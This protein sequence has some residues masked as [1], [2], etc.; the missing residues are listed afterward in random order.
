MADPFERAAGMLSQKPKSSAGAGASGKESELEASRARQAKIQ[1]RID[2]AMKSGDKATAN[3]HQDALRR[4]QQ[5]RMTLHKQ[6]KAAMPSYE[7][8]GI[9][10]ETGPALVHEGEMVIP[11]E[12]TSRAE[13]MMGGGP[14]KP[15]S[16]MASVAEMPKVDR[17]SIERTD[18]GGFIVE[19]EMEGGKKGGRPKRIVVMDPAQL[20]SHLDEVFGVETEAPE[21]SLE[22]PVEGLAEEG[23][24]GEEI[25]DEAEV[26][27]AGGEMEAAAGLEDEA[28]AANLQQVPEEI[29]GA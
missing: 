8:G 4:E 18:N 7:K 16:M 6:Q 20:H 14:P 12:Q 19:H 22:A 23:M 25:A 9:V 3:A 10:E 13:A 29:P 11:A 28:L 2:A 24:E 17:V 5:H 15:K 26:D 21:E 1:S 27:L